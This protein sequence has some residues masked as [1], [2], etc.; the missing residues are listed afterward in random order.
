MTENVD[1]KIWKGIR[2]TAHSWFVLSINS[3][4][5]HH[6]YGKR[7]IFVMKWI[8]ERNAKRT[9]EKDPW[10]EDISCKI[11]EVI[12]NVMEGTQWVEWEKR[13]HEILYLLNLLFVF[14]TFIS[15]H[16]LV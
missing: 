4:T 8:S 7:T 3:L 5:I 6:F 12:C 16:C 1:Y 15:S 11:I 2:L 9:H 14:L 10:W 13:T